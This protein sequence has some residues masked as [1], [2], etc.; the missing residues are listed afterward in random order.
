M[1]LL[2]F[3]NNFLQSTPTQSSNPA[4]A[5]KFPPISLLLLSRLVLLDGFIDRSMFRLACR[6]QIL[7]SL[8]HFTA[9][10]VCEFTEWASAPACIRV[11]L[12]AL[13]AQ[14]LQ[15][16]APAALLLSTPLVGTTRRTLLRLVILVSTSVVGVGVPLI[17]ATIAVVA[18]ASIFLRLAHRFQL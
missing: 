6:H 1:S 14:A 10:R 13:T 8:C 18:L 4:F 5:S 11:D 3:I 2:F 16:A 9:H 7:C 15:V 17:T 12:A